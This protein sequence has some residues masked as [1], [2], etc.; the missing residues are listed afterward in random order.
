[1]RVSTFEYE[2]QSRTGGGPE[3]RNRTHI[4]TG[5]HD[6]P[7]QILP[8]DVTLA[9]TNEI[10]AATCMRIYGVEILNEAMGISIDDT[11]S[12]SRPRSWPA[13]WSPG[14]PWSRPSPPPKASPAP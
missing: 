14:T 12:S 9:G 2:S 1:M 10:G 4:L 7:D 5:Q 11:C 8:F 13:G 3:A 6:V